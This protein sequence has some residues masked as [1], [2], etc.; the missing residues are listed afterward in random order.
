MYENE[1]LKRVNRVVQRGHAFLLHQVGE[2]RVAWGNEPNSHMDPWPTSQICYLMPKRECYSTILRATAWIQDEQLPTGAWTTSTYGLAPDAGATSCSV[3]A[4]LHHLG[5][6]EL[7]V[8]R[9][10]SW[11]CDHFDNGW[12]PLSTLENN[13]FSRAKVYYTSNCLRALCRGDKD[14]LPSMIIPH[15]SAALLDLQNED[16][17][18]P[19]I[20]G[21]RSDNSFT[22]FAIHGLIDIIKYWNVGIPE[23]AILRGIEFLSAN[24]SELGGWADWHGLQD[25]PDA[26]SYATYV[27]LRSGAVSP[28]EKSVERAIKLICDLQTSSGGWGLPDVEVTPLNWVTAHAL[29]GL[30]AYAT[31][32]S[33]TDV[34]RSTKACILAH[35]HV[36]AEHLSKTDI[37][38]SAPNCDTSCLYENCG[39]RAK[40]PPNLIMDYRVRID[41]H[42]KH[43][44]VSR[45]LEHSMSTALN[46]YVRQKLPQ[47]EIRTALANGS[48]IIVQGAY[49]DHF[50]Q[51]HTLFGYTGLDMINFNAKI[52]DGQIYGSNI[53][54]F[55]TYR[56]KFY[57]A[58]GKYDLNFVCSVFP[59]RDYVLHYGA[60]IR[61]FALNEHT[62]G[63]QFI[64]VF[65][66]PLVEQSLGEWSGLNSDFVRKDDVVVI[67]YVEH[68]MSAMLH[69][70]SFEFV[71]EVDNT[72]YTSLRF[73]II[74]SGINVNLIGVKYC[75][76]GSI[77]ESL[78]FNL[79]K[80][81]VREI[82]YV[83][84]LGT[85][86]SP[87]DIYSKIFCPSKYYVLS[88][89]KIVHEVSHVEHGIL[90]HFSDLDSGAHAS[91]PT[92]LEEDYIQRETLDMLRVATIDNEIS[93][94]ARIIEFYNSMHGSNIRFSPVH[95]ATDY[96]RHNRERLLSTAHDLSTD[97]ESG[98]RKKKDN[99]LKI[100]CNNIIVPYLKNYY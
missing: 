36:D 30:H 54:R 20:K 35:A 24:Q 82:I 48:K 2:T 23:S 9:G 52:D 43:F 98:S 12:S 67:G 85:L 26:T 51:L 45:A 81:G 95:F 61:H 96:I 5:S 100:A 14:Y 92:V 60:M 84:K 64:D 10:L 88:Y 49:S 79:V 75:F 72:F 71:G 19:H 55:N 34:S 29:M 62:N 73:N 47:D 16:G 46:E 31:A 90:L 7:A 32:L 8:Q 76:W 37:A 97:K 4:L 41:E 28:H 22:S 94:I 59:G 39:P 33:Q 25:S 69:D 86:T 3:I 65:R 11:I 74:E 93:K 56:P 6:K 77:A 13:R 40:R 1:L 50:E 80:R 83:A 58:S 53:K 91:V 42:L 44:P 38:I 66:Y 57:W 78:C 18:W 87:G 27:L 70:S 89:N 68:L 15:G 63:D 17:G 21:L 99:I